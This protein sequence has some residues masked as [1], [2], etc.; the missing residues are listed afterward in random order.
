VF[1]AERWGTAGVGIRFASTRP[2]RNPNFSISR[3]P[4][5]RVTIDQNNPL[6]G[7]T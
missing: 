6:R 7:K 2:S 3:A 1:K 5:A 4:L